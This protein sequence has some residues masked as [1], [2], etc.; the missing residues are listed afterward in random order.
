MWLDVYRLYWRR[1]WQALQYSCLENPMDGGAWWATI[2][3]FTKGMDTIGCSVTKSCPTFVTPRTSAHQVPLSFTISSNSLFH[4]N[5]CPLN[6]GCHPTISSSVAFFSL[7][8][9]SFPA[10]GSF[11]KSQ[12]FQ[13][14]SQSIGASAS[15]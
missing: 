13:S 8:P 12:L 10:S 14:G 4:S 3:G 5:P 6:G 2:H 11:P 9:Q 15:A 7:C 1:K